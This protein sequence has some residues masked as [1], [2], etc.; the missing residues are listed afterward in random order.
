[1]MFFCMQQGLVKSRSCQGSVGKERH[2]RPI[3]RHAPTEAA[4]YWGPRCSALA[5]WLRLKAKYKRALGLG[6]TVGVLG[7]G[8]P[9]LACLRPT[10]WLHQRPCTAHLHQ[11][12]YKTLEA[13]VDD[14]VISASPSCL[15][16]FPT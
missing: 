13:Y 2:P 14:V 4:C 9:I 6:S 3:T 7:T 15:G 11:Q 1:M 8:V 12:I 16:N 10:A 5:L